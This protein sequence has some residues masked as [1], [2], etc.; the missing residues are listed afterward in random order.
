M[1][2]TIKQYDM[3][4]DA[5]RRKVF[6]LLQRVTSFSLWKRKRDAFEIFA[7]A[8]ESALKTWPEDDPEYLPAD[9]LPTVFEILASYDHGL[10]ELS[11]GNR[12]V[13][14]RGGPLQYAVDRYRHVNAYFFPHP[15]YWDRGAQNA[16]YPPKIDAFA[17][18]LHASEY[19]IEYAPFE[20]SELTHRGAQLQSVGSLLNPDAYEHNFYTLPYPVFPKEL[21]QV[22]EPVGPVIKSGDK[23]PCD[24]IWEPI[25]VE[26]SKLL[27][28]VPVGNR[29]LRGSGC[30]NYLIRDIRAPGLR[31]HESRTVVQTH[32]RLLWEDKRYSDGIIPDESQYFLGQLS[33]SQP[34]VAAV[35]PAQTGDR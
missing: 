28:I 33:V 1:T 14:K 22:P 2:N 35:T 7:S 13:W 9:N 18:L 8:Y 25:A 10:P 32:W 27:G 6:W 15:G 12:F 3:T 23:V 30:F 4:D 5:T 11:R 26:R 16:A 19:Q 20:S 34:D 24:G 31:S 29:S 21:Q 17:Q